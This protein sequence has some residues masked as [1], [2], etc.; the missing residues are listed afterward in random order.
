MCSYLMALEEHEWNL[1]KINT[2]IHLHQSPIF[3]INRA[4]EYQHWFLFLQ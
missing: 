4:K 2:Y 1:N 3:K